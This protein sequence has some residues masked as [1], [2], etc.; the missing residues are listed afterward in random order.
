MTQDRLEEIVREPVRQTGFVSL[1]SAPPP[2]KYLPWPAAPTH[3]PLPAPANL[4]PVVRYR[5]TSPYWSG[6]ID[7]RESFIRLCE[8]WR[9]TAPFAEEY[10]VKF[11]AWGNAL[12]ERRDVLW[13][14]FQRH[15]YV[16]VRRR[17]VESIRFEIIDEDGSASRAREVR[18]ELAELMRKE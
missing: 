6:E 7:V 15:P 13:E 16:E 9:P 18:F 4:W 2:I 3:H 10:A 12:I 11:T 1:A 5:I 8:Q 17:F 14:L